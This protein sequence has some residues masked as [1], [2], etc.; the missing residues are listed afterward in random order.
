MVAFDCMSDSTLSVSSA[1]WTDC[2][3]YINEAAVLKASFF[4]VTY[5]NVNKMYVVVSFCYS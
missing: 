4:S 2:D 3:T 1:V 5:L